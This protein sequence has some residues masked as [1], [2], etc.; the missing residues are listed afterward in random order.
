MFCLLNKSVAGILVIFL[1]MSFFYFVF[2]KLFL[3][4]YK[5]SKIILLSLSIPLFFFVGLLLND[6]L[7][8]SI[9]SS[10]IYALFLYGVFFYKKYSPGSLNRVLLFLIIK[11]ITTFLLSFPINR[12]GYYDFHYQLWWI[13]LSEIFEMFISILIY[14][15]LNILFLDSE[16]FEHASKEILIILTTSKLIVDFYFI[17]MYNTNTYSLLLSISLFIIIIYIIALGL[18][19]LFL[20]KYMHA[21]YK[22]QM[23]HEQLISMVKYTDVIERNQLQLRRFKHDY[24]NILL[25][26]I[27]MVEENKIDD[28]KQYMDSLTEYSQHRLTQS[29]EQYR[30]L[31]NIRHQL[32]KSMLTMKLME[33][34]SLHIPFTFE[35]LNP[36]EDID[37]DDFD[38]V[39][40]IGILLDNAKE[41]L[42]EIGTGHVSVLIIKTDEFTEISIANTYLMDDASIEL[43]KEA[44]YSS[45]HGHEGLG[46]S[47]IEEIKKKYNNIFIQYEKN[48]T[49][50]VKIIILNHTED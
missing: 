24:K 31:H 34:D 29:I 23:L 9:L 17:F 15:R 40:M 20:R 13:I 12:L 21:H 7:G 32:F 46:L 26:M 10:F 48:D 38:L 45:K 19:I 18:I 2:I 16:L 14:Q 49:F 22:E 35:C 1:E 47:N 37:V 3:S 30:D 50:T 44:R 5:T 43:F 11:T 28:L 36:I 39:R 8:A 27:T 6:S 33:F 41:Y 25:A 42:Q 4:N